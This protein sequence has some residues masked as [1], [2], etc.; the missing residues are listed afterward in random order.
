M[1]FLGGLIFGP[2]IFIFVRSPWNFLGFFDFC[3]HLIICHRKYGLPLP[4]AP[5]LCTLLPVVFWKRKI[6]DQGSRIKDR[7]SVEIISNKLPLRDSEQK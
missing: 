7:R 6:K 3:P 2:G 5:G 1:V 4:P